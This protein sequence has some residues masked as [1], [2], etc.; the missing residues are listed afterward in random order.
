MCD[1]ARMDRELDFARA[2]KDGTLDLICPEMELLVCPGYH[3]VAVIGTG[4]I[5]SDKHGRLYFRMV[6]PMDGPCHE[7]LRPHKSPGE[8]YGPDDHV[9]LRAVDE[10]GREWRSNWM[11]VDVSG[12]IPIPNYRLRK[13]LA[14]IMHSRTRTKSDQSFVRILIPDT[15]PLPFDALT[16]ERKTVGER[17]IAW[18][19][20]L[21]HHTHQ[22]GEAEVVFRRK[23]DNWLSVYASRKGPFMPTWPGLLCH[24]LEF[25]TAQTMTP[26]VVTREFNE[27]EDLGLFSGPFW[28]F[29]TP[30]PGPVHFDGPEGASDFWRILEL[31][32]KHVE[33]KQFEDNPLL[34]ELAGVR[35]GAQGSFQAACLILGVG[36]ESLSNILL[37]REVPPSICDEVRRAIVAH[38]EAWS[39]DGSVKKRVLGM[40]DRLGSVS[41][42]DRLYAWARRTST[43]QTLL[44]A[45]K[46]LRHSKAHGTVED[47]DQ[48]LYD[49]YYSAL[50]LH[51]RLVASAIGYDGPITPTSER[52]WGQGSESP[53]DGAPEAADPDH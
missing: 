1:N 45:W 14:T 44:D 4:V 36:I 20:S 22:I 5:R 8:M 2:I 35:R 23:G 53:P 46:R 25:A 43:P 21:D 28:R 19:S 26:A 9:M 24:A 39:G 37:A 34:D 15:P 12:Q 42:A 32:F 16:Q 40:L 13:N 17:E 50:E 52:G 29:A 27:R 6:W 47:E 30:M 10:A 33:L 31:F 3:D 49:L 48:R 7:V 41:A 51:Y 18:Q 11:I 38:V